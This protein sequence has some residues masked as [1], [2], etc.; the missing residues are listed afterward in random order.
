MK[1]YESIKIFDYSVVFDGFCGV[2]V[3]EVRVW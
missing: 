2:M 1:D 3:M